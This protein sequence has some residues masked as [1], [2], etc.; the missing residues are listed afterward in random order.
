MNQGK[1]VFAQI[2]ALVHPQQFARCVS[3]YP[4]QRKSKSLSA[5]DQFLCM[6]FAQLTFRESLRDIEAC[7]ASQSTLLYAMGICGQAKRTNIAYANENRD[8]RVFFEVAQILVRKARK[9]YSTDRYISEIEEAVYAVDAS[10][11]DLC[12]NLFPW[13]RF[14]KSKAAIKLHTVIDLQGSIPVFV[15]VTEG[16]I[17][18][19]NALDWITFEPGAFYVMDRGYIDFLRLARIDLV[20]SFFVTRAKR[21]MKFYVKQSRAVDKASGLRSDQTI[22]LL[23]PKS[24]RQ[25]PGDIRRVSFRD[26]ETGKLLVFLS[27]NFEIDAIVVAKVYKARW[28]IELFFKWI[29]QNLRIKAFYG[30]SENAVKTQIWVAVSTYL[31]VAILNKTLGIG[32]SMSR[33]LQVIS[34][35]IFS[36]DTVHQLLTKYDTRRDLIDN[37]NQLM[38]NDF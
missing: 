37:S 5:W 32:Q 29:K 34:V 8:W 28:Q 12:L 36:K 38:F 13:A 4:M 33:M 17:H 9:L 7:L 1:I 15:A 2:T 19:V 21:N 24:R 26:A 14:R 20:R 23:C 31:M 18:D 30:L 22:R 27:N 25:Y 16:K 3:K 11:I 6:A 35:N 10:T